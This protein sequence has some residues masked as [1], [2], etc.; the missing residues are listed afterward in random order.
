M[1]LEFGRC[2]RETIFQILSQ[3]YE[4]PIS[5]IQLTEEIEDNLVTPAQVVQLCRGSKHSLEKL[6]EELRNDCLNEKLKQKTKNE[7][8]AT[9]LCDELQNME[10]TKMI[11]GNKF[12]EVDKKGSISSKLFDP[13]EA[14]RVEAPS[15]IFGGDVNLSFL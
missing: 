7:E 10:G 1:K 9:T 5:Q 12:L 11:D 6:I 2:T 3:F 15:C 13:K 14:H 8:T 4:V